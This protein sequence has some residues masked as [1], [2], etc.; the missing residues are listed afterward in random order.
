MGH[1]PDVYM[2]AFVS[3]SGLLVFPRLRLGVRPVWHD[4]DYY[5]VGSLC[6][7]GPIFATVDL[8]CGSLSLI[9]PLWDCRVA[10]SLGCHC[11]HVRLLLACYATVGGL[12]H[13]LHVTWWLTCYI[14]AGCGWLVMPWWDMVGLLCSCQ[15]V[16]RWMVIG[17]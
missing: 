15:C 4:S 2:R 3:S 17:G 14:V 11:W 13:R 1:Y 9:F 12:Y 8:L 7:F 5:A 6:H 10:V 16:M